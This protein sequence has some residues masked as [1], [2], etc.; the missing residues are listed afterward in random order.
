V[1]YDELRS[2]SLSENDPRVI[3]TRRRDSALQTIAN[4]TILSQPL[5]SA[6]SNAA[7]QNK[8]KEIK[9]YVLLP[10]TREVL[11][12]MPVWNEKQIAERSQRLFKR[13]L[14]LWP[15]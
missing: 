12:D 13:A 9:K 8:Q 10:I 7:W 6:A 2:A 15:R 11:D 14:A 1:V 5:N 4:L 3:E